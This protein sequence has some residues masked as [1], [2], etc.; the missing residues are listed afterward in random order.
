MLE[1]VLDDRNSTCIQWF[2]LINEPNGGWSACVDFPKRK[3][4]IENL[5]AEM[6]KRGLDTRA[7]IIGSDATARKDYWSLD[8]NVLQLAK[9][10]AMDDL[11]EYATKK[12][13]ETGHLER[14]FALKRDF[15]NRYDPAGRKKPFV[16]G[17][18]G[19]V[20]GLGKD[21]RPVHRK[22]ARQPA[23]H[24]RLRIRRVNGRRQRRGGPGRHG[25][26]LCLGGDV[27]G[28]PEG[29]PDARRSAAGRHAQ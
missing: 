1:H 5:P 29:L 3:Q 28:L 11:H 9:Q 17:D 10:T 20:S 16:M 14:V 24:L 19:L 13:V 27:A 6:V 21:G 18:I 8:L 7:G 12:D 26:H 22:G 2:N 15:A 25:W 23:S 4:G